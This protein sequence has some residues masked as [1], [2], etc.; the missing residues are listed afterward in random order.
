[1]SAAARSASRPA[2]PAIPAKW[3]QRIAAVVV[4][5]T[6]LAA[7]YL[8]WFRDSSFVQVHDVTITGLSSDEAPRIRAA[9]L[10][11]ATEMTT[12]H[13]RRERLDQA[14]AGYP[15]V[16]AVIATPDFP[17]GLRLH[18]VE[19]NPAAVVESGHSR[20]PVAADGSVLRGVPVADGSLPLLSVSTALPA[21]RVRHAGTLALLRVAA[22]APAGFPPRIEEITREKERGIVLTL[23]AGPEI[24]FGEPTRT[25][26]KWAAA[27]RVLADPASQGTSYVDVRIPERPGAGGFTS[28]PPP[29]SSLGAI[30]EAP[31]SEPIDPALGDPTTA[32]EPPVPE[33]QP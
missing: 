8:L 5:L 21:D 31:A 20:M 25:R 4:G 29:E 7:L 11:E 17:H 12:L 1:M 18:V 33:P 15:V 26:D 6:V 32:A 24:V 22:A 23:E 30:E 3:R 9:L 2:P 27:L 14:V 10:A 13:V 28:E 16:R 19:H